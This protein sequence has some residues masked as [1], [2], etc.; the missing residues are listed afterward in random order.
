MTGF[1]SDD[2]IA[3][4]APS[5]LVAHRAPIP[6]QVVPSD[7]YYLGPQI[8][9]S[10]RSKHIDPRKAEFDLR[11]DRI[12]EIKAHYEANSREPGKRYGSVNTSPSAA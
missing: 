7:E 10:A 9:S 11:R 12:A 4:L 3:R 1:L 5:E 8:K 6:T 2:D